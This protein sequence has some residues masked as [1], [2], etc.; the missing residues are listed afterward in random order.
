M[1]QEL[2]T[3]EKLATELFR[4]GPGVRVVTVRTE[5]TLEDGTRATT[6]TVATTRDQSS[7]PSADK[8]LDR[9]CVTVPENFVML[10]G[11]VAQDLGWPELLA[12]M[13]ALLESELAEKAG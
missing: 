10:H 1:S 12:K 4:P 7:A 8:I 13:T 9:R 11:R 5:S 3:I 2:H 6:L